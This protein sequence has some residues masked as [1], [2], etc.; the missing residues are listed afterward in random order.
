MESSFGKHILAEYFEC[1]CIYLDNGA[2]VKSLMLEAAFAL[3]EYL[4]K[5]LED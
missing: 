1:E 5:E 3:P 4:R 2:A